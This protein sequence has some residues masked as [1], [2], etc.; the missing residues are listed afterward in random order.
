MMMVMI[1]DKQ[2]NITVKQTH[3]LNRKRWAPQFQIS[4][5]NKEMNA[6]ND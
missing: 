5:L 2:T 4:N 3:V 6:R 1:P